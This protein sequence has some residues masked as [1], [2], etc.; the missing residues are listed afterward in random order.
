MDELLRAL[1]QE[2]CRGTPID[3][4]ERLMRHLASVSSLVPTSPPPAIT[5]VGGGSGTPTV[6]R[7]LQQCGVTAMNLLANTGETQED[8]SGN[9]V[10]AGVLRQTFQT[11]DWIDI[12]KQ[13]IHSRS[14]EAWTPWHEFLE[15]KFDRWMRRAYYLFE[16]G[17]QRW[18]IQ[19]S[20]DFFNAR[21]GNQY[22]VIP[23]TCAPCNIWFDV[24]GERMSFY[25]F[26]RRGNV[27]QL[28][29]R[30]ALVPNATIGEHA[31]RA[32]LSAQTVIVGPGDVHF[33][34]LFH[35]I[36]RGFRELLAAVPR[37]V[38]IANLTARGNDIPNF[39]LAQFLDL[40]DR[41]LPSGCPV[42]VVV[43]RG[44]IVSA[45]PL[46]DDVCGDSYGRFT[47][48]RADVASDRYSNNGQLVHDERKLVSVLGCIV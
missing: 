12:V 37:I 42:M 44:P 6:A 22:R 8:G 18:G 15:E 41:Y 24:S 40:Y 43:H 4:V 7:A 28:A 39:T 35:F 29:D 34:V 13:S 33:T 30:L 31:T 47:L 10:G 20:I 2:S 19:E 48:V 36:V 14:R 16:A 1:R 27:S 3:I 25:E 11:I 45:E 9:I 23:T 38:L 46:C 26:S 5:L 17:R 32:L 21:M